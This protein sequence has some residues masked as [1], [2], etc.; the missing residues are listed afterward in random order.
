MASQPST[1]LE[2][3]PFV[4]ESLRFRYPIR[5]LI[6]L[7]WI[8]ILGQTAAVMASTVIFGDN[9]PLPMVT[10]IIG[11]AI[12]VNLILTIF[13]GPRRRIPTDQVFYYLLYDLGQLGALLFVTGGLNNPFVVLVL[14]PV[15]IAAGFLSYRKGVLICSI[16]ILMVYILAFSPFPLPW[17]VSGIFLPDRMRGGILIALIIAIL[18][19]GFY[20]NKIAGETNCLTR[21]L[22]ATELALSREQRLAS[23]GALA[24]A[25]AHE[26]GSPLTTITLVAKELQED[27]QLPFDTRNDIKL[28]LEQAYRCRDI[29]QDLAMNCS[30]EHILPHEEL[31]VTAAIQAVLQPHIQRMLASDKRKILPIVEVKCGEDI[32]QEI[33]PMILLGPEIMHGLGNIVQNALQFACTKVLILVNWTSD[34]LIISL[35]D[36]GPGYPQGILDRLGDPYISGRGSDREP[37]N[38]AGIHLG[39]GLFIAQTLLAQRG[40]KVYFEN[41][42]LESVSIPERL[43]WKGE[44]QYG[45]GCTIIWPRDYLT[46]TN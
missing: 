45:A 24:A 42:G 34:M 40:V 4:E 46:K 9:M 25:A 13:T 30:G 5:L 17:E 7:R 11:L 31:P 19:I 22:Q 29:L 28:M 8:A 3:S 36:D 6:Y 37:S 38:D 15:V 14:T 10:S 43:H 2:N 1:H 27:S 26:L 23:L 32:S 39:L 44:A 21:A 20:T 12:F 33:E 16:A 18:F 35:K 41:T